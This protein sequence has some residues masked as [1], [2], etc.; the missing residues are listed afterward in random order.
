MDRWIFGGAALLELAMLAGALVWMLRRKRGGEP[1][2]LNRVDVGREGPQFVFLHGLGGTHRYWL[3]A[4][5]GSRPPARLTF[6][7]LL[8]FGDSP[9]PWCRHTVDRHLEQLHERLGNESEFTLVGHSLGAALALAYA[10]RYPKQVRRLVLLSL[11][12]FGGEQA[13]YRWLRQT[14]EGWILTNTVLMSIACV[15]TRRI[16]SGLLPYLRPDLPREVA[17][18]IVKHSW[19]ASTT[20]LWDVIYR[21]DL[22]LEAD[23]LSATLPVTCIHGARDR[24]VPADRVERLAEGR[25]RWQ[26][27]VLPTV[28]HH[29]WLREPGRCRELIFG[30]DAAWAQ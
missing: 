28:D 21:H 16:A 30:P 20:S 12:H 1:Q 19:A 23:A 9:R 13:A 2:V 17:E 14:P 24:T 10:A 15:I 22:Q 25:R 7:D 5:E 18:D 6:I 27:V 3:R 26:A 11:P 29:P 8:G 4:F